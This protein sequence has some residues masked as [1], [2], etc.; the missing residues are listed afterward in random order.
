[1]QTESRSDSTGDVPLSEFSEHPALF[2]DGVCNLCNSTVDFVIK[3][4][5]RRYFRFGSLQ[6]ETA[7]RVVPEYAEEA[8]LSTVVLVTGQGKFVRST[9][10]LKVLQGLGGFWQAVATL[11][12]VLPRPVRDWF[13][14]RIA[15]MRYRIWGK[16]SSCRLPTPEERAV[17]LP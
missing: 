8:G 11:L 16:K 5:K 7:H 6:G 15:G 1:M 17:F 10:I 9:A 2:F 12:F 4:D 13:Y 14:K 3:R